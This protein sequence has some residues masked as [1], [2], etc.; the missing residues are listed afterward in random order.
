MENTIQRQEAD[1]LENQRINGGTK[2]LGY[3]GQKV[4]H[5]VPSRLGHQPGKLWSEGSCQQGGAVP[6]RPVS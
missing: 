5:G 4:S 3:Q 2:G 1:A 6:D